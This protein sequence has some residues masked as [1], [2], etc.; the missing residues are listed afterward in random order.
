MLSKSF[1]NPTPRGHKPMQ[2]KFA[3]LAIIPIA[4]IFF[5]AAWS[6][7]EGLLQ[8]VTAGVTQPILFFSVQ[9]S[10]NHRLITSL[11]F[12]LVGA[13]IGLGAFLSSR[14]S[15][16]HRYGRCLS[17]LLL[18]G[19]LALSVWIAFL[20]RKIS[21][22]GEHLKTPSGLSEISLKLSDIHLYEC[23]IFGSVCVAVTAIILIKRKR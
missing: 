14:S 10:F 20:T 7:Y 22:F 9:E 11:S 19:G 17:I 21:A 4:V 2:R 1:V 5:G 16:I 12:A 18:V 3:I 6:S 8:F 23:G 13:I 15:V